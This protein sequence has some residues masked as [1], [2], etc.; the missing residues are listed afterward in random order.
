MAEQPWMASLLRWTRQDSRDIVVPV[1]RTVATMDEA[2]VDIAL[3]SAWHGPTGALISNDE[4]LDAVSTRPDRFRALIS[5]DLH[6][7]SDAVSTIRELASDD[8]VVGVRVVPWLWD[9]PPDDRLYYP[10]HAACVETGLPFCTQIG[11][12]G[13]LRSS[14]TGRPI[15]HLERV[16]LDFP[17]LVV[18]GG[19]VGFPW[20]DEVTSLVLKFPNFYVDS[21]AYAVHRLPTAFVDLAAGVGRGRVMFGTNHPMLSAARALE[22]L[23]HLGWGDDVV[24]AFLSTTARRVFDLPDPR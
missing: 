18:V 3:L 9:L 21:S 7:P 10:V 6:R 24:A 1:E 8:A 12:T 5:V 19:H 17:E 2:D 20:L 4:V 16:L 13:P 15:P 14:E 22:G 11:H 23:P